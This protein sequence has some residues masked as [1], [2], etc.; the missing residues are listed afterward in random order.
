[1]SHERTGDPT[2]RS[3]QLLSLLQRHRV[4]PGDELA[5]RLGVTTRTLRRDVDRLRGLGYR[6]DST[7]GAGGGY[8]LGPSSQ[9]PPML[10][11]DDDAVAIAIGLRMAAGATIDGIDDAAVAT[12]AKLEQVLPDRVRRRVTALHQS[13]ETIRWQHPDASLIDGDEL[14]VI[15]QACRDR[16]EI[17]FDYRDRQ[18]DETTRLVEPHQLVAAGRR[19]YLVAWDVRRA[20]WRTFRVDRLRRT[21]LAGGRFEPRAL[22]DGSASAY[23]TASLAAGRP[24]IDAVVDVHD[25]DADVTPALNWIDHRIDTGGDGRRRIGLHADSVDWLVSTV[26]H[27]AML[28]PL[29]VVSP[30][31]LVEHVA[32]LG[33]RFVAATDASPERL[34]GGVGS[35]P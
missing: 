10:L 4:W 24:S 1:M 28:S 19:W 35:A 18:G 33:D 26:A 32:R 8:R 13:I 31:V 29:T 27:L 2:A 20:D 17:R 5:D 16:E 14:V 30:P 21:T 12:M 15:A 9:I 34:T 25:A 6:V 11:D 3:L 23:V 22:P 7:A